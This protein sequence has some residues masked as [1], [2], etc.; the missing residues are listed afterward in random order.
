MTR[1]LIYFF[2]LAVFLSACSP[3]SRELERALRLAGDNRAELEK[4]LAHFQHDELKLKAAKFL[5][6]NMPYHFSMVEYF[7]SP[8][9]ERYRPDIRLF[10]NR[11]DMH[12]H[13]N[14]LVQRGYQIVRDRLP[15][16]TTV[17]SEFLINNIELAFKAWQKPWAREISF[18][19]FC[20][21]IL[22][23]RAHIESL[24]HLRR[25]MMERF[26]PI[27]KAANVTTP[28][29]ACIVL[30]EY[31]RANEVIRYR[32]VGFPFYPIIDETY[33]TGLCACEGMT[34]LG[35]FIMRAVGIPVT[36]DFTIWA[37]LDL[38]HSWVAVLNNGIFYSFEPAGTQP[39]EHRERF[40]MWNRTPAKV[41]RRR[42]DVV[43]FYRLKNDDNLVSFLKSPLIQ[44]VTNEY[45]VPTT[46]IKVAIDEE[47]YT[48]QSNQ[49]YL[50]VHNFYQWQPLAMGRRSGS[51]GIFENVVGDNIFMVADSPDGR[52]LRL[53]TPPFHVGN[54]GEIRKFIPQLQNR[55]TATMNKQHVRV[56]E[57]HTL[58]YWDV[59]A[60]RFLPLPYTAVVR[61]DT[62]RTYDRIPYNALLWFAAP[63]RTIFNQRVFFI[64][65]DGSTRRF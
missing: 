48:Y 57:R 58:Y 39:I 23:Y 26:T 33:Q 11:Y 29:E 45:L 8:T 43:D 27:L 9:G 42:F 18:V 54:E 53:I 5:I 31:L 17:N 14:A 28:L 32:E 64:D 2:S 38:G 61:T 36:I 56:M 65:D 62:T 40:S 37:R 52:T 25:Y 30:N 19:D 22:P 50:M 59:K 51:V 35:V 55:I 12:D 16:I 21:Y 7:R 10:D 63:E 1:K 3:H 4:V 46:T 20:K 60:K 6:T 44:D 34:N 13:S 47:R 41:Y 15:D 49:I 24:S